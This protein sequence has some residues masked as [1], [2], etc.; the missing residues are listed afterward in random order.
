MKGYLDLP[1][2]CIL[3]HYNFPKVITDVSVI[4][5]NLLVAGYT[6]R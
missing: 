4:A 5:Q 1:I 2:Q 3:I 6:D